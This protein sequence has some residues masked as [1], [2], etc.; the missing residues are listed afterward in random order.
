MMVVGTLSL[1]GQSLWPGDINNNGIVNGVDVLYHAV[2]QGADGPQRQETGT[3]W[4]SYGTAPNWSG[5]FIDGTNFSKADV[6]GKGKVESTDRK[7]L[8]R[9][10]YGLTHGAVIPDVYLV[11]DASID[12]QLTISSNETALV[13]GQ[14]LELNLSLGSASRPVQH[15]YGLSFK[16]RF[17]PAHIADETSQPS[18]NPEV[19]RLELA[20]GTWINPGGNDVESFVHLDNAAGVL[21]VVILR[22]NPGT[23]SGHGEIASVMA[24][25]IDDIIFLEGEQNTTFTI[26]EIKLVD[27]NLV[28][29]PIAGST[30]T[31]L[32]Q[33]SS[34]HALAAQEEEQETELSSEGR[35]RRTTATADDFEP[36]YQPIED[37]HYNEQHNSSGT[38]TVY[39]NPV[40]DRLRASVDGAEEEIVE[41]RLF[42]ASG[43]LVQRLGNVQAPNAEM[44]MSSL[45]GGSYVLQLET[46]AGTTV[47]M[48]S[49]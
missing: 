26:D 42:T 22:K 40:V 17:N 23:I 37:T 6:N 1:C 11:G 41:L 28:E 3:N 16:L 43:Q 48:I 12:P 39:P 47:K 29:Y 9:Q 34:L 46:T 36:S 35:Q 38:I 8:W 49:K 10:N 13:A 27:D 32:T 4:A 2:A 30:T 33:E 5:Q 19:V 31:I 7:A 25:G 18:W 44:D 45:P 14:E 15:F 21:E 20:A 24:T